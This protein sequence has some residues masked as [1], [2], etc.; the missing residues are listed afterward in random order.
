MDTLYGAGDDLQI[1]AGTRNVLRVLHATG[2]KVGFH[3]VR[4]FRT[5]TLRRHVYP[6]I[7]GI[8]LGHARR[9]VT[10]LYATGLQQ[11]SGWRREWCDRV[12]LGFSLNGLLGPQMQ[13]NLIQRELRKCLKGRV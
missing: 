4:R 12:G 6:K 9:T 8:W 10:D 1:Q 13:C 5:E 2:N 11:D 3:A 7:I